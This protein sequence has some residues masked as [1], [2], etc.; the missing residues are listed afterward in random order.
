ML[1]SRF[2]LTGALCLAAV[3]FIAAPAKGAATKAIW[4]PG[5]LSA[6][7]APCPSPAPCSAFPVYRQL[8]V[9]VYQFQLQFDQIAPSQPANPRN[10]ADP[11]YLWPRGVDQ[12]VQDAAANGIQLAALIQYSPP[13]ANGGQS[14]LWSPNP[15]AFADFAYAASLRYPSI[16]RWLIWGEPMIGI[17]YFP[18][19]AN[20]SVGPQTYGKL[21]DATYGA[22][23]QASPTNVVA[24][25][26]TL[27][28]GIMSV[29]Q[30]IQR[31]RLP[32]GRMPRMDEWSHNPYDN[33]FPRLCDNPPGAFR[34]INDIDTLYQEL[35]RAYRGKQK[36]KG[37][38]GIST[39][40]KR[41]AKRRG[42]GKKAGEAIAS[43]AKKK[44]KGKRK[45]QRVPNLWLSEFTVV[46]GHPTPHFGSD[47]FVS[48]ED[49]ARFITAAYN[50]IRPLRYVDGLGWFT[51]LD[52]PESPNS[53]EW[54]LMSA[55]G[56]PK[57][58]FAAY[59]ASP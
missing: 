24:G 3:L 33:R 32:N 54:G 13:W 50:M 28:Q 15:Q 36:G 2:T 14:K 49:Q 12:V 18:M 7:S 45:P 23:K 53:A 57:P 51:L 22:L 40:C 41:R 58:S 1:R 56:I 35:T 5:I 8:G 29:S 4:G 9:D 43:A 39:N 59:A 44:K 42:K 48:R 6:G 52:Q 30:F 46:S 10:P 27:S 16:K 25:G 26:S 37:K 34:G 11:A 17:N 21:V 19:D 20:S 47:F 55:T 38:K 31:I